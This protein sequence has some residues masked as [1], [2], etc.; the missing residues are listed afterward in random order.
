[1]FTPQRHSSVKLSTMKIFR[2]RAA[3]VLCILLSIQVIAQSTAVELQVS[4][5]HY[6]RLHQ[7]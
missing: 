4:L 2:A 1:M 6:Q 7:F 5:E 3:L